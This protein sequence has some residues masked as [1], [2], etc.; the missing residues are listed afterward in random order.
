MGNGTD[1]AAAIRPAPALDA[2]QSAPAAVYDSATA[3]PP[4]LDELLQAVQYRD[5]I[6]QLVRRDIVA[7]YKRSVLGVAWTMLNPLGM[8]VV[9]LIAFSAIFG[10]DRSY[11]AYLLTGIIAWN[12]FSQTTV[13]AMHQ[14]AWGGA[15]LTR[16]YLPRATFAFSS[17]GT[18][19]VNFLL[20][21][22]PLALVMAVTR[23]QLHATIL[24]LPLAIVLLALFTLGIGLL[25]SM[26][27]VY[28]PDVAEMYQIA[29]L[30]WMYLTPIFYPERIVPEAYRWWLFNLN[31]MYHFITLFRMTLI[32]GAWPS[33]AHLAVTAGIAVAVVTVCW[34]LFTAR[35]NEFSYRI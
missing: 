4:I 8:M 29:V 26:L 33:A 23:T 11:A 1:N 35:A 17:V 6:K 22:V 34:A 10:S 25:L 5:L 31:P 30:G 2:V 21:M 24:L 27:A 19:L 12:F 16:I 28:F 7:R 20:A 9:M 18:G 32:S 15:L 14:L 3:P 13:T